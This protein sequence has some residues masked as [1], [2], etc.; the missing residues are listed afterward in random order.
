MIFGL[1]HYSSLC[2]DPLPVS[3]C[4][5]RTCPSWSPIRRSLC[6]EDS[7]QVG[8]TTLVLPT[9]L[10]KWLAVTKHTVHVSGPKQSI[11]RGEMVYSTRRRR[12]SE[13]F[14]RTAL[15][16]NHR[17]K[18]KK[19]KHPCIY[20]SS[21]EELLVNDSRAPWSCEHEWSMYRNQSE[22]WT[23]PMARSLDMLQNLWHKPVKPARV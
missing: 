18:Y 21:W 8:Q 9:V 17:S 15:S 5:R 2:S 7:C 16:T 6:W 1:C 4:M 12:M 14:R 22:Y 13:D 3:A 11:W 19:S 20:N 23:F 10:H